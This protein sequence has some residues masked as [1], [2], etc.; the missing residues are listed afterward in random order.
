MATEDQDRDVWALHVGAEVAIL[1]LGADSDND[2]LDVM[3]ILNVRA[4]TIQLA[5]GKLYAR[6]DGR[7]LTTNDYIV[8][9]NEAHRLALFSLKPRES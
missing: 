4:A 8:P 7:G 5:N 6:Q 3:P 2:V 9:A 1:P